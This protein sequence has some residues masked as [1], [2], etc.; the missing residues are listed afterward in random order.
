MLFSVGSWRS[1]SGH[2]EV[3]GNLQAF[4]YLPSS[5]T[6]KFLDAQHEELSAVLT[7]LGLAKP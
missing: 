6:R 5:E 2:K 3:A 4:I 7:E 1:R